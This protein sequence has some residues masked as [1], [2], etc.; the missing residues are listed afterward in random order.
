MKYQM[1]SERL[2]KELGWQPLYSFND[3][4]NE[5]LSE[6]EVAESFVPASDMV[7]IAPHNRETVFESPIRRTWVWRTIEILKF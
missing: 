1:S 3:G 5:Y 2:R 4:I 6:L 7:N